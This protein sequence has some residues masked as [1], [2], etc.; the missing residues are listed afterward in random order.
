MNYAKYEI[1]NG[2]YILARKGK[3]K[4]DVTR[5]DFDAPFLFEHLGLPSFY[6][7]DSHLNFLESKFH[8]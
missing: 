4:S 6:T 2:P 5:D 8:Y 1:A 3:S 7:E